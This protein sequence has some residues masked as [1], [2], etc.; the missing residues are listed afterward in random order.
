MTDPLLAETRVLVLGASGFI[1]SWVCRVVARS[2]AILTAVARD[3]AAL[4]RK[5]RRYEATAETVG[6]DLA[7]PRSGAA[8]VERFRPT[9]VMNL[10][11]GS[12]AG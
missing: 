10:V 11:V 6:A 9:C 7:T 12:G 1:G 8:L 3:P 2:G 5:L 4:A